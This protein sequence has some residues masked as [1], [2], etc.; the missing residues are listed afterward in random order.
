MRA[1]RCLASLPV[2]IYYLLSAY[3]VPTTDFK[4]WAHEMFWM[5]A[6]S[7]LPSPVQCPDIQ[8]LPF[9]NISELS[10][11]GRGY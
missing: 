7:L 9:G 11:C 4:I 6:E 2:V 5:M 1:T 8:V 3:H 10:M